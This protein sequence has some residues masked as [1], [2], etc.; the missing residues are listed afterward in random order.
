V[1]QRVEYVRFAELQRTPLSIPG[2]SAGLTAARLSHDTESGAAT[3]FVNAAPM[4]IHREAG[5]FNTEVEILVV[6]GDLSIGSAT[7][8]RGSYIDIGCGEVHGTISSKGGCAF[9]LMFAGQVRFTP[10]NSASEPERVQRIFAMPWGESP[11]YEGRSKQETPPGLSV[12]FLRR[13]SS[14]GAYTLITRH[15]PNWYDPKLES[16]ETWEELILIDGD[17]LMGTSGMVTGG[18]YIFRNGDIPHGPQASKTGAVWFARG[19]REINFDYSEVDWAQ[20][21]IDTYLSR[22]DLFENP[23]AFSPFGE[24]KS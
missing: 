23:E 15:A 16:H 20:P 21:M 10:V 19:N 9:L 5:A 7:L 8:E 3:Y 11:G 1:R 14:T 18:T 13:D 12:K 22:T 24:W 17:Y 6:G 4:W 2:L